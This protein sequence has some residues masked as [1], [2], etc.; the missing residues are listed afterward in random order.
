M[1]ITTKTGKQIDPQTPPAEWVSLT[2]DP[3]SNNPLVICDDGETFYSVRGH[4][5]PGSV[6]IEDAGLELDITTCFDRERVDAHLA[7]EFDA[8]DATDREALLDWY[9]DFVATL[10][11]DDLYVPEFQT[12]F[13][14]GMA[15]IEQMDTASLT[16]EVES[17]LGIYD[18]EIT[19]PIAATVTDWWAGDDEVLDSPA[20][21]ARV[22]LTN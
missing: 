8:L 9:D 20:F 18:R 10:V 14:E 5:T 3:V 7:E 22:E 6:D 15:F 13:I 12:T 16:D 4:A 1:S 21:A 2:T 17:V 19:R 11:E